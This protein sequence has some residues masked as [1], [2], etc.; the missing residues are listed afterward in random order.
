MKKYIVKFSLTFGNNLR[1]K[2]FKIFEQFAI[3]SKFSKNLRKFRNNSEGKI[4]WK[5][6][7]PFRYSIAGPL[8]LM[9]RE[10]ARQNSEPGSNPSCDATG[11][12]VCETFNVMRVV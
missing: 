4:L 5:I 11:H 8:G 3:I 7:L 6:F 2:G 1:G 10:P 12:P 9:G